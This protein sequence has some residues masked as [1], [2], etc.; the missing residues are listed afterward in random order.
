MIQRA[1]IALLV[2][3]VGAGLIGQPVAAATPPTSDYGN[4]VECRYKAPGHGPAYD[5]RL[6]KLVVTPPVLYAKKSQQVVGWRI[7]V[8]RATNWGHDPWKVTYHSPIQKASATPAHAAAFDAMSVGVTIPNVDNVTSVWY[9]VTLKLYWYRAN[10]SVQS[11][12]SYLMPYL[13]LIENGQYGDYEN[14]CA[15]GFYEGP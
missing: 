15:A 4:T 3:L 11:K 13:K 5:F 6:K 10:G 8:T 12:Q 7:V 1:S 2:S 14:V 9:H